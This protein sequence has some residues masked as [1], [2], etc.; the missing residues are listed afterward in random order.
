MFSMFSEGT[1]MVKT[2]PTAHTH[3]ITMVMLVM[4]IQ[5]KTNNENKDDDSTCNTS[6]HNCYGQ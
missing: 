2:Q 1:H 3:K 5:G 6:K 4:T